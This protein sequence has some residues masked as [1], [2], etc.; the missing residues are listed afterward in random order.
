MQ[1]TTEKTV[2]MALAIKDQPEVSIMGQTKQV[3]LLLPNIKLSI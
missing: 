3:V 2:S 1:T